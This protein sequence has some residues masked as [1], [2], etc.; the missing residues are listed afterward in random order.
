MRTS[1]SERGG[2][3]LI[4]LWLSAALA[5]IA[6]SVSMT[7]RTETDHTATVADG[8]RAHYLATGS[9]DRAV[10]WMLW[11]PGARTSDG[12]ARFWD[13]QYPRMKMSYPTGDVIVEMI[14]ESAKLNVNTASPDDLLAVVAAVTGDAGQAREIAAAIVDWR[15]GAGDANPLEAFYLSLGP[16]FRPRHAS[17]EEIEELLSVR[18]VTP[19]L[20]YG[21]YVADAD[22]RLYPRGGLRDC[23][24]VWGT[25]GAFDVNGA[26]P[27]LLEAMGM[28]PQAVQAVVRRRVAR[29]FKNI[30]EVEEM[31]IPTAHLRV[32]GN[33]MWTMRATAR[34]RRPDGTPSEV[35][36]SAAAVVKYWDDP[37]YHPIPVQVVRY[38]EDGWS[39]FAIAPSLSLATSGPAAGVFAQ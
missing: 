8:L 14:A 15:S 39:E 24:S 25:V 9:L 10:Q 32:G 4:V 17:L 19:E 22:G 33:T 31:G 29:P 20:F 23:L 12:Q 2:A 3:L 35:L 36:R 5:A 13:R 18:G 6:L 28:D 34:L 27:A 30:G 38:Y 1:N 16:T 7:V 11:G 37:R 26:S 21:N